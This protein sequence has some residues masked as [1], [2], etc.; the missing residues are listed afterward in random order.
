MD[1]QNRNLLVV[2]A[3]VL[4][5]IAYSLFRKARTLTNLNFAIK[6]IDLDT[7]K[8]VASVDLRVIN[9]TKNQITINSVV[10]DVLFQGEAIGTVSYLKDTVIAGQSE[11]I[12]RMPVK[13]NP[14]AIVS[15]GLTILSTKQKSLNFTVKGTASADNILF[16]IEIDY[17]YSLEKDKK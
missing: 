16:P 4:G 7:K 13:V 11:V 2:G 15:L 12:L 5:L 9:P 10:C 8:K 3:G 14:V 1:K 17:S 6:G